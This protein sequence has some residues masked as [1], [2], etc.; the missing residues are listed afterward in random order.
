MI[1][2]RF[3]RLTVLRQVENRHNKRRWY[4]RCDYGG[5]TVTT[6]SVLNRGDSRSCGCFHKERAVESAIKHGDY[7]SSTYISWCNMI[8]RCTNQEATGYD[9]YG[10]RG[11]KICKRW[12]TYQNFLDDMGERP[13]GMT[14]E[15]KRTDGNYTPK[16]CVWATRQTQSKNRPGF[17]HAIK[18]QGE[19]WTLTDL[20]QKYKINTS[21]LRRRKALGWTLR[22]AL[23]T[24][25]RT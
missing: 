17:V 2:S 10:G 14:L 23:T 19:V 21:T 9:L 15:R 25:V 16:N 12:Q 13:V 3:G 22:R 20:A 8:Q 6:T 4:C 5:S 1:G 18:W 11:I 24:P 7:G